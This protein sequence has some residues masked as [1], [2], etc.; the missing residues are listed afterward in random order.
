MKSTRSYVL[1]LIIALIAGCKKN[2]EEEISSVTYSTFW[3]ERS[4]WTIS[5]I[6]VDAQIDSVRGRIRW[7][8]PE[9][10]HGVPVQDVHPNRVVNS[11]APNI[12]PSLTLRFDPD[13]L[14]AYPAHSWGGIMRYLGEGYADLSHDQFLEFWLQLPP[15]T[16]GRLVIDL[17]KISEDALPNGRMDT[18]DR[19]VG[20]GPCAS[21]QQECGNGLLDRN[22][23]EDTGLD[24]VFGVDPSDSA[25][26]N[27]EDRPKVPSWDDWS[28]NPQDGNPEQVNGTERNRNAEGGGY[29]DTEDL[30]NDDFLNTGNNYFS[31]SMEIADSTWWMVGGFD[32]VYHWRQVRIP[33]QNPNPEFRRTV[34]N[35]E[36]TNVRWIR[37]YLTG[38][39][40]S[41]RLKLVEMDLISDQP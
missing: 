2:E 30:N 17:G 24:Q 10:N 25:F 34:G 6:P 41:V 39:T 38:M 18:E 20:G 22:P 5:S 28:Y 1:V 19:P 11:Q 16:E 4:A 40:H 14:S 13:T 3:V 27:G 31:Y 35:P 8:N 36:M 23:D 26:W 29:P 37:M 33:I 21:P 15:N 9:L 12:L 32:N 7:Y